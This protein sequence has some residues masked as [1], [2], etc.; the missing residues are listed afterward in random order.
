MDESSGQSTH[1]ASSFLKSMET[2]EF[3]F[4]ACLTQ[5]ILAFVRPLSVNLQAKDCDL[6]RAHTEA[7]NVTDILAAMRNESD[8]FEKLY[9]RSVKIA[10]HMSITPGKPRIVGRQRHRANAGDNTSVP[11]HFRIN[12][13]YPFLDHVIL[14]LSSRFP[15]QLGD[16]LQG[17]Y[18]L[19][20][21]HDKL[22]NSSIDKIKQTFENDLPMTSQFETEIIRWKR[23]NE[24]IMKPMSLQDGFDRCDQSY[25]PNI[26]TIFQLI[27]SL[28]VGSCSCERS[29]SALRRLKTWTSS[30][31]KSIRLNGLAL[32]YINK[33]IDLDKNEI[34]RLWSS[35]G[36]RRI[37]L[38]LYPE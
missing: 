25:F 19:P 12:Y 2:F 14:H 9:E 23:Y 35:S 8:S 37:S 15:E 17:T 13:F 3:I 4:T 6:L 30:S 16:V 32:M 34:L 10:T 1:D 28:P 24:N 36:N 5:Y 27:L 31:M 22:T 26:C 29:F 18:L 20:R 21:N 33:D 11:D 7:R 38:P